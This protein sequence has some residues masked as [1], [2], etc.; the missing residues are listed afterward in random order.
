MSLRNL[1]HNPVICALDTSSYGQAIQWVDEVREHIGMVKVGLE[2]FTGQG[3]SMLSAI[4]TKHISIFLDLKFY[5]IPNT[6]YKAVQNFNKFSN[7]KMMTV[8]GSGDPEMIQLAVEASDH[9]DVIAVTIL[10]S[11]GKKWGT[12]RAVKKITEKALKAGAA[13][14]VCS[15]NEVK[16]LRK[17]FGNDFKIIV[18]GVRPEWYEQKD[19]QKRTGTPLDILG[20]GADYLVIGRPITA[21]DSVDEAAYM[22]KDEIYNELDRATEKIS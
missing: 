17:T 22:I 10:T 7:I 16:S 20:N 5:D 6:V 12:K 11:S 13:G 19:D 4:E 21:S 9:I 18:P 1:N 8:H 14:V 3:M 15:A 2:L